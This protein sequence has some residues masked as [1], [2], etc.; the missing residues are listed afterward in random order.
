MIPIT[1]VTNVQ[2]FRGILVFVTQTEEYATLEQQLRLA[3]TDVEKRERQLAANEGEV[4]RLKSDLE[5]EHQHKLVEMQEASRRLK[6]DC[7][8]QI[9]LEK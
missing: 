5:R 2:I 9:E 1:L 3:L 6:E 8:H 7:L 4:V